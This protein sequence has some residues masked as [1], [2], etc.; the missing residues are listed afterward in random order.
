MDVF[1]LNFLKNSLV[2]LS[3]FWSASKL[4]LFVGLVCLRKLLISVFSSRIRSCLLALGPSLLS[5]VMPSS[6]SSSV[7]FAFAMAWCSVAGLVA[8]SKLVATALFAFAHASSASS[9]GVSDFMC[10]FHR[11]VMVFL[12]SGSSSSSS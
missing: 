2:I 5:V 4:A 10:P 8:H 1:D 12:V 6:A 3:A 9:S 7:A 11:C